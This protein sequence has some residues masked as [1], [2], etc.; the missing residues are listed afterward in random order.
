MKQCFWIL[1]YNYLGDSNVNVFRGDSLAIL[2]FLA[3]VQ[4]VVVH[5]LYIDRKEIF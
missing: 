1:V 5:S 2:N 4:D 3:S